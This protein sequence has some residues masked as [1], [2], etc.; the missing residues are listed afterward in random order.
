MELADPS[1]KVFAD[2][3]DIQ[4]LWC[5]ADVPLT[6]ELLFSDVDVML[7][8]P[9]LLQRTM[10]E[11]GFAKFFEVLP[12]LERQKLLCQKVKAGQIVWAPC[13]VL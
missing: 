10:E 13:C 6:S 12:E 8:V 3:K 4:E 11:R 7:L 9:T 2:L 1:N 5:V